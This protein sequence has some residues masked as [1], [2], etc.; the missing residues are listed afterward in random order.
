MANPPAAWYPD[1]GGGGLRYWEGS[2]WTEHVQQYLPP[3]VPPAPPPPPPQTA[4]PPPMLPMP[5][6]PLAQQPVTDASPGPAGAVAGLRGLPQERLVGLVG[7]ALV[8][9]G[10]VMPWLS[11]GGESE[12]A[13]E[14]DLPWV[15]TGATFEDYEDGSFA[16]GLIF[17]GLAALGAVALLRRIKSARTTAIGGAGILFAALKGDPST[18]VDAGPPGTP[19]G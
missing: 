13:F 10:L 4:P 3:V 2:R 18:T 15:V 12:N 1:P 6:Q 9:I 19:H 17:L 16:H 5:A 11:G 8:V 14:K 7:V